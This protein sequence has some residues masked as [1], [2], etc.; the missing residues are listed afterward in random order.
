MGATLKK[1]TYSRTS[2]PE[3]QH[4]TDKEKPC[5][6][7]THIQKMMT[8]DISSITKAIEATF[9]KTESMEKSTNTTE[10]KEKQKEK[11]KPQFKVSLTQH[12]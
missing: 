2:F 4:N 11:N 1:L 10:T 3:N 12:V 5:L 7:M 8:K 6:C 9:P